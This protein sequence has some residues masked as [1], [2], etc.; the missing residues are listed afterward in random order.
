MKCSTMIIVLSV[1]SLLLSSEV[2]ATPIITPH[3][4]ATLTLNPGSIY[5]PRIYGGY[6]YGTNLGVG[7][8]FGQ[9]KAGSS[10]PVFTANGPAATEQR[11]V[12]GFLGA[13]STTYLMATGG[14]NAPMNLLTRYDFDGTDPVSIACP[15]GDAVSTYAWTGT[16]NRMVYNLYKPSTSRSDLVLADVTMSPSFAVTAVTTG[17]WAGDPPVYTQ[18]AGSIRTSADYIRAVGTGSTYT[19][20]AYYGSGGAGD[21]G[22]AGT[23]LNFWTL[24]IDSGVET[25]LGDFGPLVNSTLA[26]TNCIWT[27]VERDGY[28]YVQT[29]KGDNNGDVVKVFHMTD[30]TTLERDGEGNLVV[31]AAYTWAQLTALTGGEKLYYLGFDVSPDG[32]RMLI[33][34][35]GAA[36]ELIPLM[37]DANMDDV[38]DDKD[39]SILGANW[40]MA[41]GAT[42]KD[43]DF[44]YDGAVNDKDAAILAA[45]WTPP[46]GNGEV[47]EPSTLAMLF[48]AAVMAWLVRRSR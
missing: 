45:H 11:M 5:N 14:A 17:P 10:T 44:N 39:A 38:V 12:G 43:G 4:G 30:A 34:T 7:Q 22:A 8:P 23:D 24:D 33:S 48:G 35:V 18:P 28:L 37:G 13:S 36:Y 9:W 3:L 19:N 29:A 15:V 47:P 16:P 1:M 42:W 20:N 27:V 46:A 41:T 31:V 26:Y 40:Q 25:L 32:S 6:N 2:R 21:A